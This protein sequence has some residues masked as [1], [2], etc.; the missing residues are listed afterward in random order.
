MPAVVWLGFTWAW[1][2][3][4]AS[5]ARYYK[6]MYYTGAL[7]PNDIRAKETMNPIVDPAGDEYFTLQKRRCGDVRT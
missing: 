4:C 5:R 3:A 6:E 2:V 7:N 1:K